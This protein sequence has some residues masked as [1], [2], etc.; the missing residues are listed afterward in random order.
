MKYSKETTDYLMCSMRENFDNSDLNG[1]NEIIEAS[2]EL[3]GDCDF[4]AELESDF[5]FEENK[6][7]NSNFAEAIDETMQD[8]NYESEKII[9]L[10]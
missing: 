5:E 1:M 8:N 2:K 10:E 7:I 3:F 9:N 4:T 6:I